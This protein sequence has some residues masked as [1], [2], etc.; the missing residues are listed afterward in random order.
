MKLRQAAIAVSILLMAAGAQAQEAFVPNGPITI[1]VH[2]GPGGGADALARAM[3]G[4]MGAAKLLPVPVNVQS[5]QGG[6]ST[7][8]VNYLVEKTGDTNTLAVFTSLYPV[9]PLVQKDASVT[10]DKLTPIARLVMEPALVVVRADSP[11]RTMKDFLEAAKASPGKLKQSGGSIYARDAIM[12]FLLTKKTG[13]DWAFVP[14][15]SAGERIAAL[16][17]G[18]VDMMMIEAGEAGELVRSGKLRAIAQISETRVPGFPD[19]PTMAESGLDI[20][21]VPQARGIVGP[22]KMPP[23][24]AKYYSELFRKLAETP[25]WKEYMKKNQ[26]ESA[27]LPTEETGPFLVNYTNVLREALKAGGVNVLR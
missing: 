7:S 1:V 25:E 14:F 6:G 16:L 19:V 9:D 22:P 4:M 26:M 21:F 15:P 20:P 24:A 12:R 3:T 17:G 2:T 23:E 11:Y 8:A 13:A 5:K 18:H 27:Y 10:I